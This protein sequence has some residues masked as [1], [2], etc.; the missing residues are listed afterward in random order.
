MLALMWPEANNGGKIHRSNKIMADVQCSDL[1]S[2]IAFDHF[3][4]VVPDKINHERLRNPVFFE[5]AHHFMTHRRPL[6]E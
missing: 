6:A 3:I 2:I 5:I 1:A 4:Q